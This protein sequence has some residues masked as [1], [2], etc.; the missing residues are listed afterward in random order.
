MIKS[1]FKSFLKMKPPGISLRGDLRFAQISRNQDLHCVS[2]II[3]SLRQKRL[4]FYVFLSFTC[5][6]ILCPKPSIYA[7]D[8]TLAWAGNIE[9]H[10]AGY[11]IYYKSG[12]SGAPYNGTNVYEGSSPIKIP[13]A[14][15]ADPSNPE[16]T[17]HGLSDTQTT[18]MV[19]TAY[20][21][22]GNES[23]FSNEVSYQPSSAPILSSLSISGYDFVSENNSI[24]FVATATFSDN[25]T[26]TVTGSADWSETSEYAGI[27]GNGVLSASEVT[28]DISLT[29][30]AVY[31]I[32]GVTK[33]ATKV[34]TIIDVPES[35]LPPDTPN[36]VSP[37]NYSDDVEVPLNITTA[38]FSD[39]N[40]DDHFQSQWQISE[41]SDFSTRVVDITSDNYL[42]TF[43]VPHMVL[44]PDHTYYVRVR[45][46]DIYSTASNW[47]GTV[48]FTTANFT[49]DVN[50]NGISD[51]DE[52]DDGVDFNLDGI[53]D[54]DQPQIIKCVKASDGAVSI[55]VEKASSSAEEIESL[56]MIDPDTI[57]DTVNRPA[58]LIFGLFAYR[59][60][61]TNPGDTAS[62][63][64][65]F[66]GEIFES[67]VFYKYDTISGWYDYSEHT[68]FN[69]DRKSITLEVKDGG[70][71]DSDGLANGIIVDPGGI[72]S[73]DSSSSSSLGSNVLG[74][75]I[76]TAS[77][78]SRFE[79]HVKLL[80]RFRDVYL[81]PNRIGRSFVNAYYKYS[82]PMADFIAK[83][84]ILR[85]AVRWCLTPL[86]TIS[87][88]LLH[89]G[90][91][92][93]LLLMGLMFFGMFI[94][95]KKIILHK[96][97]AADNP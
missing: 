33:T 83:H 2:A 11:Y 35:N 54:K 76:G 61:V 38:A 1:I 65:Y 86:I 74:C 50:G 63:R 90:A 5:F 92:H 60:R 32:G 56:E 23:G 14:V 31:S 3:K 26:R 48:R 55:G 59:L 78:E 80:R 95:G 41:Q 34:V 28:E 75:F 82:P 94:A 27:N 51:A 29:V 6:I 85:T 4:L 43:S 18:Y 62:I 79:K 64:I 93:T 30:Q 57:S 39:A 68:T 89:F 66:S 84:D 44:K 58:D 91:A 8:V 81:M 46:F 71:G 21:I 15:F 88:M 19:L 49:L 96:Q 10:L 9:S 52:V 24:S 25:T 7:A 12:T 53:P 13:I 87:W 70:F 73:G 45:F 67:D 69:D 97:T 20:D 47:S 37:E 42:T 36:I 77:F 22:D 40:N 17:L 16:Y 72:S